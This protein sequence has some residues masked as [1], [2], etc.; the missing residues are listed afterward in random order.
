MIISVF[1]QIKRKMTKTCLVWDG[2]KFNKKL[3]RNISVGDI[4]T[5]TSGEYAPADFVLLSIGNE[6]H[7]CYVDVSEILGE[8]N[9]KIKNPVKDSQGII[10]AFDF[11]EA[12]AQLHFLNEDLFVCPPNK[13]FK[14]FYR[15]NKTFC[16]AKNDWH[17]YKKLCSQ[18][19][20]NSKHPLAIWSSG[21]YRNRNKSLNKQPD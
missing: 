7:Q 13:D 17:W 6:E 9:L 16:I 12:S 3:H 14:Y 20:E 5:L 4:I 8:R 2:T 10:D 11:E 18:R 19:N 15:K 21:V 1:F